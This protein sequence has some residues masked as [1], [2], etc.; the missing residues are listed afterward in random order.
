[1]SRTSR[2]TAIWAGPLK[3]MYAGSQQFMHATHVHPTFTA[4]PRQE[5]LVLARLGGVPWYVCL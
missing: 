3:S 5:G 1:M 2:A 4:P